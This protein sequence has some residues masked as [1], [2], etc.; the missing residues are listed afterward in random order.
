MSKTAVVPEASVSEN[1]P[2]EYSMV[3]RRTEPEKA[4][5]SAVKADRFNLSSF[6]S[7]PAA[8]PGMLAEKFFASKTGAAQE[9][10]SAQAEPVQAARVM[11]TSSMFPQI[12]QKQFQPQPK[13]QKDLFSPVRAV[14]LQN[15]QTVPGSSSPATPERLQMPIVAQKKDFTPRPR[16]TSQAFFQ[17]SS[18]RV[19]AQTPPRMQLSHADIQKWQHETLSVNDE[20]A[21]LGRPLLRALPP[22]NASP[23]K[24]S[25]RSPLKAHTPGRVVEFTSSVLS[26]VEQAKARHQRR[27]SLTSS[28]FQPPSFIQAPEAPDTNDKE[29]HETS[30]ISMSDAPPLAKPVQT[31]RL[32]QTVWS[33]EHWLLLDELLQLRRQAPFDFDFECR[34]D[35]YLGKTVKSQGESMR[36]ER[37]H[38][39]CV[40][41]F[42][43]DVG[44][45]DEGVLAKRLFAL[46]LGEERRGSGAEQRPR[47]V[48]FH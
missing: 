33:R 8:I 16:Q 18:A 27:T 7:S 5:E 19:A 32:S 15:D 35:K 40:D 41:A 22:K 37:W 43:A 44:G 12:A 3:S 6:F 20:A 1:E 45:W 38:L 24:S 39:D 9:S 34:S 28:T 25:L 42:R 30:D 26:P 10:R 29:N 23:T 13:P 14:Q 2:D 17:P 4:P 46:I 48:M 21:K 36:L 31:A 47:R 11:P